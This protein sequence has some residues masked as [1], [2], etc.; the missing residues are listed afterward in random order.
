MLLLDGASVSI[1]YNESTKKYKA[2]VI[3]GNFSRVA[4]ADWPEIA[5]G[6]AVLMLANKTGDTLKRALEQDTARA[7]AQSAE[8]YTQADKKARG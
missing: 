3:V 2:T 1:S 6:R 7:T 8:S 5:I 4:Q